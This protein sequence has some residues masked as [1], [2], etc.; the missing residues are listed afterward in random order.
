MPPRFAS[1]PTRISVSETANDR[2]RC[3]ISFDKRFG[4]HSN[5]TNSA[6]PWL[7]PSRSPSLSTR[8]RRRR[9][10][11]YHRLE[12]SPTTVA[13]GHYW[14][15]TKPVL[16]IASGRH[17]RRRYDAD[18]HAGSTGEI[19]RARQGYSSVAA[20][21]RRTGQGSRARRPHPDRAR[22]RE[23]RRARRRARSEDPLDRSADRLRLQRLQRL[24]PREL[25]AGPRRRRS[26]SSIA[27]P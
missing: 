12:A 23:R 4:R 25:R 26:S 24:R 27:R 13:Y 3:A 22:V 10:P 9:N 20:R 7:S 19:R 15:E 2:R 8:R 21:D 14:A 11:K 16:T 1:S 6:L 5:E 17:H 18:E